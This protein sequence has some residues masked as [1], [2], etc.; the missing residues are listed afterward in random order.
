MSVEILARIPKTD[1]AELRVSRSRWKERE[2]IDLR[3]WYI[4]AG[5]DEYAPSRKGVAI[6]A[7]KLP[8]LVAALKSAL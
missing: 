3:I 2:V 7:A 6:D 8:E 5:K 4:P 1:T